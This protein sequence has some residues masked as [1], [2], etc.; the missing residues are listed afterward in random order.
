M[1][2]SLEVKTRKE[3]FFD[4]ENELETFKKELLEPNTRMIVIKGLR[5]T[6]KSSL[7]RVVLNEIK[8]PHIFIDLRLGV[9]FTPD[10]IYQYFSTELSKFLKDKTMNKILSKIKGLEISG[11]KLEFKERKINVI[12]EILEEIGKWAEHKQIVLAIDEAQ[13]L[14]Y[15]KGF[16]KILAHIYD[17]DKGIKLVLAGSEVGLL[18]KVLGKG[19]P[20]APL[21][22]RAFTEITLKKLSKEK[23]IEF[24]KAGFEQAKIKVDEEEI[25]KA[26]S[27]LDGIIGWLTFYGYLRTRGYDDALER[28]IDEGS[29]L[30]ADEFKQFLNIRQIARRR[31][32][33]IMKTLTRPSRWS[34]VKRSLRI[35]SNA[36]DKQ[37]SNYLKELMYYGFIEKKDDLYFI[38]DP[39]LIEAI[40]RGYIQ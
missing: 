34:E 19:N 27:I 36:S 5:R 4:M 20:N 14:R 22:G 2:F 30:I 29:K 39:L 10:S 32:I 9:P 6:G 21:F 23:S 37:I 40:K 8:L 35:I 13:D 12:A 1:Y 11:L 25:N 18:D 38:S 26:V 17:Y 7:M 33:E 15:I 3:D 28:S 16:D 24:L 31:Y